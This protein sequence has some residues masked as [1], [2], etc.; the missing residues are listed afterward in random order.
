MVIVMERHTAEDN[1]E[2]VTAELMRARLR[3]PPLH[4]LRPDGPRRGRQRRQHRSARVRAV[5]R[6]AGSRPRQR[7]VQ[8]HQPHLASGEDASST[9]AASRSAAI[10]VV[11]MAG[12]CTIES[13]HQLFETARRV[14]RAGARVLRG[15]AYKPR[16]SPYAFQGMGVDGLKLLRAAGDEFEHGHGLRGDGDLADRRDAGVC[17]HPAGRRAQHAELQPAVGAGAD[18]QADPAQAR[19]V[20]DDSGVAAGG[21]IHHGRR[22]LRRHPL[23]ARHPD[24]RDLHAQHAR[25]LAPS[26]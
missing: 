8:A 10:D 2:R 20:G 6:R 1:I 9:R 26:R 13:E 18:A 7:A 16:T 21:R 24:L 23:R 25:H 11:V 12:P 22:Q 19:H 4:R 15:G 14:A 3:R 17:G 5:R